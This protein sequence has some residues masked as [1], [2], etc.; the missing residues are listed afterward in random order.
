[1]KNVVASI[2]HQLNEIAKKEGKSYQLILIRYF[3]ERF[4]YRLAISPYCEHFCLKGGALLYAFY[5][6]KSRPTMDTDLLALK[7]RNE[8]NYLQN[9]FEQICRIPYPEDG[10]LFTTLQSSEINQESKYA[11]IRIKINGELG[12]IKQVLQIDIGFGDVITPKPIEMEYPTLLPMSN[13]KLKAYSMETVIAEKFEAMIDLGEMNSRM[14]D[15]YDIFKLLDHQA[16]NLAILQEA[17]QKTFTHRQTIYEENHPL[18]SATF[19]ENEKRKTQW[20]AFLNKSKLDTS[21]SFEMVMQE[22]IAVLLP[23]YRGVK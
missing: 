11:G 9:I 22:I 21:L 4:L 3:Q 19:Y 17:I 18:F 13:P 20:K 6:E 10:V 2:Q 15:F 7:I 14:K 12:N 8:T 5:R 16:Y 23:I 1:M